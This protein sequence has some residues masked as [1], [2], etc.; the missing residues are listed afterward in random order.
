[1]YKR[2][3]ICLRAPAS[4]SPPP[5][6]GTHTDRPFTCLRLLIPVDAPCI[7][8]CGTPLCA[9]SFA[10][11][12]TDLYAQSTAISTGLVE[13]MHAATVRTLLTITSNAAVPPYTTLVG[14]F[15]GSFS[16]LRAAYGGGK[17]QNISAQAYNVSQ[18]ITPTCMCKPAGEHLD[19]VAAI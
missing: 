12:F 16:A 10:A 11:F 7:H 3:Q 8:V 15:A 19:D 6:Y 4:G 5:S 13:S 18:V 2:L 17:D 14:Q 9:T 1:M